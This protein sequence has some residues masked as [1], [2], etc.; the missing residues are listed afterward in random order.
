M[1]SAEK[2]FMTEVLFIDRLQTLFIPKN[3]QLGI[4]AHYDGL[5]VLLIDGHAGHITPCIVAHAVPNGSYLSDSW[6]IRPTSAS[7]WISVSFPCSRP[8]IKRNKSA[9]TERR[10]T[11]NISR[12]SGLL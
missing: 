5:I 12:H 7:P 4:K 8:S 10:N 9:Q 6:R 3:N 11:E 1:R 2:T